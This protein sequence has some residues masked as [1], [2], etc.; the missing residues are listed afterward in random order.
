MPG[1]SPPRTYFVEDSPTLRENLIATLEELGGVAS[2]GFAETE[3]EASR[4]LTEHGAQWDLAIVDVF[5]KRGSGLG[6]LQACRA[7]GPRQKLVVFTS[8]ATPAMRKRCQELGVDA[9][10]DKSI[11]VDA[12]IDFCLEL[13]RGTH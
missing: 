4:W 11:E 7:R 10:F 13:A 3:Q 8:Y 12:L 5:L 9:V 2:V 6:V 1:P